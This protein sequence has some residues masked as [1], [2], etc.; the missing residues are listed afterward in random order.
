MT[1]F[2]PSLSQ[3]FDPAYG[4]GDPPPPPIWPRFDPAF[5]RRGPTYAGHL[6]KI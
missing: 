6:A 3:G 1:W 5:G 4:R 2:C